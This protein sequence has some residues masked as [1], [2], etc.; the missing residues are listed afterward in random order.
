[1]FA[2]AVIAFLLMPGLVAIAVP[3]TIGLRRWSHSGE[4][5]FIGLLP[6]GL[7]LI[8]LLWCV[9]EFYVSGK[10][11]LAARDLYRF[12]VRGIPFANRV[13]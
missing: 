9:Y 4:F 10:G 8:T 1:M 6:L 7:G 12:H 13:W 11:T 3:L 5:D 2:R